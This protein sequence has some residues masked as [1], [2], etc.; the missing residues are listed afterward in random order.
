MTPALK[1]HKANR[2]LVARRATPEILAHKDQKAIK[3]T[4]DRRGQKAIQAIPGQQ[5]QP[6][7]QALRGKVLTL[8]LRPA[9][10]L[11]PKRISTLTLP[12]CRG[13]RRRLRL[14][15]EADT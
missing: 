2:G 4:R 8:P 12:L 5:E 10:T 9:A 1:G 3:V 11:I 6:G 13:L 15:K 14:Y 7:Q